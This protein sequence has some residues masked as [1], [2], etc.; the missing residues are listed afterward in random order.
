[1]KQGA[2]ILRPARTIR[3]VRGVFL[4]MKEAGRAQDWEAIR[5]Q[6]ERRVAEETAGEDR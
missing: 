2:I 5:T 3:S 1:V 4:P 6:T